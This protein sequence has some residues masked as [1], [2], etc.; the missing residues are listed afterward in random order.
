MATGS[1]DVVLAPP[2][3]ASLHS[4]LHTV[5]SSD[6]NCLELA[7]YVSFLTVVRLLTQVPLPGP[8]QYHLLK[9]VSPEPPH[10]PRARASPWDWAASLPWASLWPSARSVELICVHLFPCSAS[11]T[12]HSQ[13][14]KL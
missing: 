5:H 12:L 10:L 1:L 8:F 13:G 4:L 6:T 14:V 2:L 11:R 7:A 3:V 9:E